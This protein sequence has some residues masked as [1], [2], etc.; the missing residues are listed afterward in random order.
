MPSTPA[1]FRPSISASEPPWNLLEASPNDTP[2][3]ASTSNE[4]TTSK[5]VVLGIVEGVTEFLPIS[6][7][8]H[9]VVT[10]RILNVGQTERQHLK[11][12]SRTR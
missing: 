12:S 5:A 1:H 4:L 11:Q 7:T 2:G 9:L 6:S 8:G 3:T 10:E